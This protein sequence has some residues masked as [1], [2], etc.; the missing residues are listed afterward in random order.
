MSSHITMLYIAWAC[1]LMSFKMA[2]GTS[3]LHFMDLFLQSYIEQTNKC[4]PID[5][6]VGL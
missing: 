5:E 2:S 3:S 4:F 6:G 1:L